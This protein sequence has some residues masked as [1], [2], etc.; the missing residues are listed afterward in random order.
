MSP[1]GT[2]TRD[3]SRPVAS[4]STDTIPASTG[5]MSSVVGPAL[6]LAPLEQHL[7]AH[8]HASRRPVDLECGHVRLVGENPHPPTAAALR[9]LPQRGHQCASDSAA[10]VGAYD[11]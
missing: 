8:P 9:D 4:R 3:N 11:T 6:R 10:L 5:G 2:G 7:V 1:G